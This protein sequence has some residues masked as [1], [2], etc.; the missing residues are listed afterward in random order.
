MSGWPQHAP[1]STSHPFAPA[2]SYDHRLALNPD[3]IPWSQIEPSRTL[4]YHSCYGVFLCARLL[5]PLDWN[6]A[7]ASGLEVAVALMKRPA[8]VN[9]TDPR[10]GGLLIMNPGGPGASGVQAL[11]Q[12][13]EKIQN[14][15]DAERDPGINLQLHET[16]SDAPKFFDVISFDPRG[17]NHTVPRLNCFPDTFSR[18]VWSLGADAEVSSEVLTPHLMRS[19]VDTYLAPKHER[20]RVLEYTEWRRGQEKILFWGTSYGTILGST[21]ATIYPH[22]IHRTILDSVLSPQFFFNASLG[23][24]LVHADEILAE[25]ALFCHKYG[26]QNCKFYRDSQEAILRDIESITLD[27]ISTPLAVPASL[28]RGPE[29][30]TSTDVKRLIGQSLYRPLNS[31]P[32]LAR[33]LQDVFDKNGSSFADYKAAMKS[34]SVPDA[35]SGLYNL[36]IRCKIDGP[37]TAACTRP[38]EWLEEALLAISCGDGSMGGTMSKEKFRTYWNSV[39]NQS[40]A[41]GDLWAEWDMMCVGWTAKTQWKYDGPFSG[42]TAHPILLTG[43]SLDPVCPIQNA[44]KLALGFPDSVVLTQNAIGHGIL[45]AQSECTEKAIRAYFQSGRLPLPNSTCEAAREP[46]QEAMGSSEE[47]KMRLFRSP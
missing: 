47:M 16:N 45:N 39:R 20:Q 15:I 22:L 4:V 18:L 29:L 19:G 1:E 30:I 33:L 24:S 11:L 13:G 42:K 32:T 31:F 41:I 7:T 9:V 10:Y 14:I 43:N 2:H 3:D 5:L 12:A 17:V 36:S 8:K 46:F 23:D 35:Q 25:F 44:H 34:V 27:L 40:S 37:Y 21:L 28:Y 26:S 6:R 38:N